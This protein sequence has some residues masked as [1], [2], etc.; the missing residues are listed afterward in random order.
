VDYRG[1]EYSGY[2]HALN[3]YA[4]PSDYAA[5]IGTAATEQFG[6]PARQINLTTRSASNRETHRPVSLANEP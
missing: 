2:P 6:L 5:Q 4:S 3:Q 1:L